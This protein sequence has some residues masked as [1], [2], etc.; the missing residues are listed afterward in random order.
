MRPQTQIYAAKKFSFEAAHM[1]LGHEGK[2]ANL[3]GHSYSIEFAVIGRKLD[4]LG[5]VIDFG[6]I[7]EAANPIIH[8]LDHST[9]L[10][11]VGH[12]SL[13]M[14]PIPRLL[15]VGELTD[16]VDHEPTAEVLAEGI[17]LQFGR[18]LQEMK[19]AREY[20]VRLYSVTLWETPKCHVTVIFPTTEDL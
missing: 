17:G 5:R 19:E 2:C 16:Q 20:S 13:G 14:I 4:R 6:L 15:Y 8:R 11:L 12:Q 3:H 7:S 1:L 18:R 10:S 9:I